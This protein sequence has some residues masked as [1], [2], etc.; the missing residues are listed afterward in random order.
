MHP[1][2]VGGKVGSF[3]CTQLNSRSRTIEVTRPNFSTNNSL[4]ICKDVSMR[5][6]E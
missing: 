4:G 6:R 3:A 2:K 1:V 5:F